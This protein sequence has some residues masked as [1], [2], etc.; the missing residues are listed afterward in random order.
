[1]YIVNPSWQRAVHTILWSC[2]WS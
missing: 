2:D 1:M